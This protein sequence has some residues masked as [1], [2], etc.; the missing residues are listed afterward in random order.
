MPSTTV[1]SSLQTMFMVK[2]RFNVRVKVKIWL[3]CVI[4]GVVPHWEI[5][6]P[7][8]GLTGNGKGIH[9]FVV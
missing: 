2:V 7:M 5:V 8:V 9:I 3:A 4:S 1:T 6:G